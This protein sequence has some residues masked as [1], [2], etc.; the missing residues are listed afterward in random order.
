MK[1]VVSLEDVTARYGPGTP[2][3]ES[4]S[5]DVAA[6]EIVALLGPNGAGKS[7]LLRVMAG[8][9]APESGTV[10]LGG[11]DAVAMD[12]RRVA[13]KI[14]FVTQTSDVAFGFSVRDVV[15]MGRAPHQGGWMAA[16]GED[17]RAAGEA[18]R[19]LELGDLAERRVDALS[20]GE[21]KRVAI[22]RALAQTPSLLLLDEPGAF[23]DVRH[24]LALYDLLVDLAARGIAVALSMHDINAAAQYASRVALLKT[25]KLVAVGSIE[26]VLTYRTLRET[27]D[28][29]LYCGVNDVTG[30]RFFLP[31]RQTQRT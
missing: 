23:L 1:P 24:Q 2:A 9:L 7:T 8:A 16:T 3:L 25:G 22:A 15:M 19:L 20:G 10:R 31:M 12:R 27:F 11:E 28:A 4:V 6:G 14:A 21:Q 13:Q 26:N 30:A 5:L 18:M 29:D 17:E